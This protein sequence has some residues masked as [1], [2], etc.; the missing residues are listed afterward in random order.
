M[1]FWRAARRWVCVCKH[2]TNPQGPLS[3]APGVVLSFTQPAPSH[4]KLLFETSHSCVNGTASLHTLPTVLS[5]L[6]QAL[7]C[8]YTLFIL[9]DWQNELALLRKKKGWLKM[10]EPVVADGLLSFFFAWNHGCLSLFFYHWNWS[11]SFTSSSGMFLFFKWLLASS[12]AAV[13]IWW[14]EH[15]KVCAPLTKRCALAAWLA[16]WLA[17]TFCC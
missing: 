1:V 3:W 12:S 15:I 5:S 9:C 14:N 13:C 4:T 10:T 6:T 2:S 7:I 11:L 17:P 8:Q 16:G